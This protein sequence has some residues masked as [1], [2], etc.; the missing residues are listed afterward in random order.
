MTDASDDATRTDPTHQAMIGETIAFMREL[1]V[2]L[3]PGLT[4]VEIAAV[5]D[6][7]DFVFSTDHRALLQAAQPRGGRWTDWRETPRTQ[8]QAD[9]DWPVEGL[10]SHVESDDFW[11]ASWG[12]RP[13]ETSAAM[14]VAR[15]HLAAWPKMVPLRGHRYL[16]AAPSPSGVPVFSICQSDVIIYGSDLLNFVKQELQN[17]P[18][19][20]FGPIR[21]HVPGWSDLAQGAGDAD[22]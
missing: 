7:F 11:P 14:G 15:T 13:G 19:T 2:E 1:G 12:A 16:P 5:Q 17:N 9:L 3:T 4:D 18:K 10:V 8:L 21:H 20:E 6:E 22:L